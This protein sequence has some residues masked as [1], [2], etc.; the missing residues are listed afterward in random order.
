MRPVS[1]VGF[2]SA[3]SASASQIKDTTLEQHPE[4]SADVAKA[5]GAGELGPGRPAC[6]GRSS[7]SVG[8]SA[9]LAPAPQGLD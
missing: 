7:A 5:G 8:G 6:A 3:L 1:R 4:N 9:A 2:A